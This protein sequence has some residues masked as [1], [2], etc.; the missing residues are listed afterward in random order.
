MGIK[1]HAVTTTITDR[2]PCNSE[3]GETQLTEKESLF[4]TMFRLRRSLSFQQSF[5]R[6]FKPATILSII[7]L[8]FKFLYFLRLRFGGFIGLS[9]K[10]DLWVS[11]YFFPASSFPVLKKTLFLQVLNSF[12]VFLPNSSIVPS[13]DSLTFSISCNSLTNTVFI[14]LKTTNQ[15]MRAWM[16]VPLITL[17]TYFSGPVTGHC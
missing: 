1:V 2:L 9:K 8:L 12:S 13:V 6:V 7:R 3:I 4:A 16:G 15:V 10:V 5:L 11:L 17:T 14:F